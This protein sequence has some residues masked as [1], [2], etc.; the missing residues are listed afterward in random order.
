[1]PDRL[2]G[3]SL[4]IATGHRLSLALIEGGDVLA[5][6]D[7][8]LDRGHAERLL[9]AITALLAP[10]GGAAAR[11]SRLVL[12]TGPGSFTGLRV[13]AAAARALALAWGATLS[14]VR[15]TLLVAAAAPSHAGDLLVALAA[16]RGQIWSERFGPALESRGAP[17]AE[18]PGAL[19]ARLP[20]SLAVAGSGAALLGRGEGDAPAAAAA[21]RLPASAFEPP[22]LLYVSMPGFGPNG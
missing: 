15:S 7:E 3:R 17:V 13:G 1:M 6:H 19:A 21:A 10:F 11:P 22:A 2:S 12:E 16:P 20:A 9:P 18:T 4:V 5:R 14:G 8:S